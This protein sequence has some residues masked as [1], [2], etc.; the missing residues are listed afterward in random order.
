M[1]LDKHSEIPKITKIN[2]LQHTLVL[3]SEQ[4][5]NTS[6]IPREFLSMVDRQN[7]KAYI[8]T[9]LLVPRSNKVQLQP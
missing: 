1:E 3:E 8:Y 9:S 6:K 4:M 2:P 5:K 7:S